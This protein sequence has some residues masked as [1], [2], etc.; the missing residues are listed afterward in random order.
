MHFHCSKTAKSQ[1]RWRGH[2]KTT[3]IHRL[4]WA[5]ALEPT[6]DP[7]RHKNLLECR[8]TVLACTSSHGVKMSEDYQK[9][10]ELGGAGVAV[11]QLF[12]AEQTG[13]AQ[14]AER[15]RRVQIK[16]MYAFIFSVSPNNV[17]F[18]NTQWNQTFTHFKHFTYHGFIIFDFMV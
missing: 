8:G 3:L 1:D 15:T 16:C 2:V 5:E 4:I 17:Y 12:G 14:I 6:S 13:D 18:W 11:D 9:T 7:S 10:R